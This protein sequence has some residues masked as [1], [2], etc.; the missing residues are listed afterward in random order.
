[1][2]RAPGPGGALEGMVAAL[3]TS[4]SARMGVGGVVD[5]RLFPYFFDPD[6]VARSRYGAPEYLV[7]SRLRGVAESGLQRLK[8][9]VRRTRAPPPASSVEEEVLGFYA[10]AVIAYLTGSHWLVSRL[11]LAEA[12]RAQELLMKQPDETVAAIGRLAGIPSLRFSPRA[13]AEPIAVAGYTPIYRVYGYSVSFLDYVEHGRRLLGDDA[14]KPARL[15]V[16]RGLVY[17]DKARA[18]RLIKEALTVYIERLV[19]NLGSTAAEEAA[20][21]LGELVEEAKRLEAEATRPRRRSGGHVEL[22]K[23][24]V[25][26]EAFPPCMREILERARRGEH[27]S[28]HERFAIATFLLNIGAEIDYV[29]D[30]F[31]A[32]PDFKEKITRYQVEHLAGLRGSGKK[33]STY[34]CE[35]MKTLGLC[36]ADCGTRSPVQAYYRNLRRLGHGAQDPG[37]SEGEKK[38]SGGRG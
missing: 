12:N 37:G 11:A 27:L 8:S 20:G 4:V 10:A 31:R 5:A 28:H 9:A 36:R 34:S 32:M 15:P 23:G 3:Y 29:V 1:V 7:V 14:W 19:E 33:Y 35:K 26:E 2:P 13:Y 6:R 25:V 30:V 24:V 22:P 18:V 17:L 21:S 38:G 16:R